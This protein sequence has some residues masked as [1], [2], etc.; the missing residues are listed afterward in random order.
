MRLPLVRAGRPD[1]VLEVVDLHPSKIVGIGRNYRAHAAELGN[2]MP[3]EPVIFLKPPSALIGAGEAIPRPA[4]QERVDYEGELAVVIGRRARRVRAADAMDVVWGLCCGND[5]TARTLQKQGGP[6]ARAKGMD[7]FCPLG[8]RLVAGLDPS[9]LAIETRLNGTVVQ[10]ARTS[11]L[12]FPV[13]TLIEFVSAEITLEP[14]DVI[15]TGTPAGVGNL[16]V[17]DRVEV[18]IEG[19]GVLA[20]PVA[21]A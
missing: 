4:A 6:W 7:G 5:V 13:P 1:E 11:D 8:P 20:N 10:S 15:L 2:P 19:I 9:D 12:A 14:G 18:E 3:A 21:E 16:R 17:G